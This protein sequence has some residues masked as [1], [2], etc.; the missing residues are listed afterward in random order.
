MRQ[1]HRAGEKCFVDYADQPSPLIDP[2]TGEVVE[3]ALFR[4]GPRRAAG[5]AGG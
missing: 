1:V 2:T 3:V 4:R 5:R